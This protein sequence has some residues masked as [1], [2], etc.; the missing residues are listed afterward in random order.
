M[1]KLIVL[2][3]ALAMVA[4]FAMSAAAAEWNFYGSARVS[5]FITDVKGAADNVYAQGLQGNSRIGANVKVS[6]ELSGRFEYGTGV[7]VRLLYGEWNFGG[8]KFL[9]GQTYTPLNLFYSNQV[10]GSDTDMLDHGG[11]YSGRAPMLRLK[12][13]D[14]QI[15]AV[16]PAAGNIDV[17]TIEAQYSLKLGSASLALAGGY[18]AGPDLGD[19]AYVVALGASM[20]VGPVSLGGNIYVGD[21][22]EQLIWTRG[23]GESNL[24]YIIIAG[25]KVNDMIKL[26]AGY[27]SAEGDAPVTG[28]T[29]DHYSY[30][31]Q[32]VITI[33]PGVYVIPEVGTIDSGNT[34]YFGAKWQINF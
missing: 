17:P 6:D 12:F 2:T 8:G 24:G 27:G 18:D 10:F 32:A 33:A 19:A 25:F 20:N 22:A 16:A 3:A 31:G 5:T 11:V 28:V 29:T 15:A 13:G 26:E 4:T 9:V 34:D 23:V 14:F 30:Y 7:N 21:N 1:K